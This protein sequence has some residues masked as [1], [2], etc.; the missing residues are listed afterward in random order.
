MCISNC[1]FRRL[2]QKVFF[3][4]GNPT[5]ASASGRYLFMLARRSISASQSESFE[6]V[7]VENSGACTY[8]VKCA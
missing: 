2:N 7:E 1:R 5:W 6:A 4:G 3:Q 8:E